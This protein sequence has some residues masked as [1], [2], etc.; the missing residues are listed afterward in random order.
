MRT[1]LVSEPGDAT[2]PNEDF[3]DVG[4]PASGQGGC[5]ILLDG[6]TPPAGETGCLHSVPWFTA[7]LGG[8]LTE[9]TVSGRDLTPAGIL[10]RAIEHTARA[11]ADTCDLSHPRT[12]QATVVVVRWSAETVEYLV[13]SDSALLLRS[14]DGEVTAVLDDRLARLPRAALATDALVDAHLRNKEGGFFTAAADPSVAA[15]AVTGTVPRGEVAALAALTDGATR[16]TEKFHQG[17]W[18]GLFDVLA[19]DGA[20]ALVDRVR[21]LESAD[22]RERAFLGRGKTHDDATVV[23]V[24]L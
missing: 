14:P 1:D 8:A 24:E 5:V 22:A 21:Q 9:L 15:R 11:H 23:F 4:L 3:A 12:P 13:L 7:R 2:R 17:D 18:T 6:V 19:K 20:R 10:S 16:W